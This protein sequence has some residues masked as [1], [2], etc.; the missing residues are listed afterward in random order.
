MSGGPCEVN[1][2]PNRECGPDGL[3][4]ARCGPCAGVR[5]RG[6]DGDDHGG[7]PRDGAVHDGAHLDDD[8]A[9]GRGDQNASAAAPRSAQAYPCARVAA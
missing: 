7:G 3:R 4:S 2:C 8:G 6:G 5:P 1:G 9:H